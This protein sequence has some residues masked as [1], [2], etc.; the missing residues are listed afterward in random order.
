[1]MLDQH[2]FKSIWEIAYRWENMEPPG[3]DPENIPEGVKQKIE[4]QILAFKRDRLAL[5]HPSGILVAKDDLFDILF[6]DWT[7]LRINHHVAK[8]RFPHSL[9]AHRFA[10]RANI[11]RWCEEDYIEPPAFW[12]GKQTGTSEGFDEIGETPI[13]GYNSPEQ[14]ALLSSLVNGIKM[15]NSIA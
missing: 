5:R 13:N 15:Q 12:T 11:L 4:K 10:Y 7:M 6:M 14:Q 1:M 3:D 8:K 2:N 9:F